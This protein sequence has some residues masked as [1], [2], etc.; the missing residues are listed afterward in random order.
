MIERAV[1]LS[2]DDAPLD[3]YQLFADTGSPESHALAIDDAG[4]LRGAPSQLDEL[5]SAAVKNHQVD[6][7]SLETAIMKTA[8]RH[9]GGNFHAAA[10]MI[11]LTY[12]Q[13]AYR[14]KARK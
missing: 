2:S 5:L 11:G 10:K 6:V 7:E 12:R 9:A 8:V 1:I 3:V 13:L 4:A 14:L